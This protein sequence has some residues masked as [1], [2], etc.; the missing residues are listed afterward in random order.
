MQLCCVP[1]DG[2]SAE[3]WRTSLLKAVTGFF[4]AGGAECSISEEDLQLKSWCEEDLSEFLFASGALAIV[5]I[6]ID[7]QKLLP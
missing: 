7:Q 3:L 6:I 4:A 5:T 1:L 2:D